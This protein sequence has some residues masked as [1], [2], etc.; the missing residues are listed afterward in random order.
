MT[1][2][3]TNLEGG[4]TTASPQAVAECF[5]QLDRTAVWLRSVPVRRFDRDDGALRQRTQN[6]IRKV[7]GLVLSLC[8]SADCECPPEDST[9][10]ILGDHALGDQLSVHT[11][12]L[13]RVLGSAQNDPPDGVIEGL[14]QQARSLRVDNGNTLLP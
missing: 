14:L 4:A 3:R 8:L 9:P 13:R 5:E 2:P 10:D 11:D 1:S 12:D 6:L 7:H